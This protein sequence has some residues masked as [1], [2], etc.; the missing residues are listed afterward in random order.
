MSASAL[1]VLGLY[2]RFMSS[3]SSKTNRTLQSFLQWRSVCERDLDS[4]PP[5]ADAQIIKHYITEESPGRHV[6]ITSVRGSSAHD[7][8]L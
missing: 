6:T 2:R 3:H 4:T 8:A 7:G 5:R 1:I